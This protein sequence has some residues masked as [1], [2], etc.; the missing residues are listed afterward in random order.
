VSGLPVLEL[1]AGDVLP[2]PAGEGAVVDDEVHRDRGLLDRDAGQP[3]GRVH[4]REG[5][6]DLDGLEARERHDVAGAGDVHFDPVEPV[7]GVE[8]GDPV[9]LEGL[10]G[11]EA[12]LT[13]R[14]QGDLVAH[15]HAAPLDPSDGDAAEEAREVEGRDQHLERPLGIALR[16]RDV[17][18][19]GLEQRAQIGARVIEFGRGGPGAA[20][21]IQERRVEL[22]GGGLEVDEQPQHLV[23]HPKRLRVGAVDLVDRHDGPEAERERLPGD[24]ASLRHRAF[25]RVHQDQHAIHHAQ[26]PL[27][28]AAEIGV[29]RRIHDVDLHALPADR[30]VLRQD[31]DPALA[32]ERVRI[33]DPLFHLLVGA[34]RSRLPQHLI[35][36]SGLAVVDV[37]DD[38]EIA[39]HSD[40]SS[41]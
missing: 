21:G 2:V 32:L 9:P 25:G 29:A 5:L 13:Q 14:Q 18:Q 40:T 30:G 35:H 20:G 24:E 16:C 7:E 26:D 31:R 1:P 10:L 34:E 17:V 39:D 15:P 41:V 28:L 27:D 38:G 11:D 37:G 12:R 36:Q 23:V 19:D 6:P 3:L 8:R 22:L 4:R 33:H